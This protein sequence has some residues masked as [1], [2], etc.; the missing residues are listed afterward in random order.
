MRAKNKLVHGVGINDADY[1]VVKFEK[2]EKDGAFV[3]TLSWIC[4]FYKTWKSAFHRCYAS[5]YLEKKP[6]YL[7]CSVEESWHRFMSFRPWMETQDWEGKHL[8]KDLLVPG[9]KVYSA[10][11][12][13]FVPQRVNSFISEN[14]SGKGKWP[15]GVSYNTRKRKFSACCYFEGKNKFLGLYDDPQEAHLSW[16]AFKLKLAKDLA[17]YLDDKIVAEALVYRYEN[18]TELFPTNS[19][20]PLLSTD[21]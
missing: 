18:Y 19:V 10:E 7:G 17:L 3:K 21:G 6:S 8:D 12:C 16:L 2:V 4:P 11:N 9:N 20:V 1:S 14:G 15:V 13:L 5:E